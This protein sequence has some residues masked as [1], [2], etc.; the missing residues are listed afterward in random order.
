MDAM[1]VASFVIA[2]IAGTL[3][4][5]RFKVFIL[6]PTTLLEAVVIIASSHQPK[7]TIAVTVAGTAVLLQIGYIVVVVARA[8]LQRRSMAR[9]S[10]SFSKS[11]GS[12]STWGEVSASNTGND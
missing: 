10:D 1:M 8:L 7:Q 9:S 6:V 5:L 3:L 2:P 11:I 12:F 4:A